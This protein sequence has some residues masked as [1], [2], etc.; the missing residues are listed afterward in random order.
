VKCQNELKNIVLPETLLPTTL[1]NKYDKLSVDKGSY[2]R[3][4]QEMLYHSIETIIGI[5]ERDDFIRQQF[6][7]R[8]LTKRLT[9]K[10]WK[11]RFRQH[12]NT[13]R[14]NNETKTL[15]LACLD[16]LYYI[17]LA[18][19]ADTGMVEQLFNFITTSLKNVQANYGRTI[20]YIIST[21]NVILP[22][23]T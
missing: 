16:G 3:F 12:I 19:D 9:F 22:Y 23:M 14:R 11:M 17:V 6:R 15:L 7:A 21:E 4:V 2:L 18:Q 5:Q 1:K 20:N 8:Y 13:L 10:R